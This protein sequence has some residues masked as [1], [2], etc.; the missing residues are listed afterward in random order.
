M[1]MELIKSK[2]LDAIKIAEFIIETMQSNNVHSV[3]STLQDF[4]VNPFY[5]QIS[6]ESS[7]VI[8]E[9][10]RLPNKVYTPL[11]YIRLTS[12]YT[13]IDNE[14][15]EAVRTTIYKALKDKFNF[16]LYEEAEY[17]SLGII[18][19]WYTIDGQPFTQI[20]QFDHDVAR[21]LFSEWLAEYISN[22]NK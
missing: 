6:E 8:E 11:G 13:Y 5:H 15:Q 16:T 20:R 18:G 7:L 12:N 10:Y 17:T 19:G 3:Y 22:K 4:G 21:N 1:N 14:D 9:Y 2:T